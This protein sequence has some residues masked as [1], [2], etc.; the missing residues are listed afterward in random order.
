M[1]PTHEECLG[2][3]LRNVWT[4]L[5]G[6]PAT[7]RLVGGT[8]AALYCGHRKSVDADI[9]SN[10]P[11]HHPRVIRRWLNGNIGPHKVVHA[12]N[13]P[14]TKF[15]AT[16]T[17]PKLDIVGK[18][19]WKWKGEARQ[20]ANGLW[21]AAPCDLVAGKLLAMSDRDEE[22]DGWDIDALHKAGA[23]LGTGIQSFLTQS[24]EGDHERLL[25]KLATP[26]RWPHLSEHMA[27]I[28]GINHCREGGEIPAPVRYEV[29]EL[30][31]DWALVEIQIEYENRTVRAT[32]SKLEEVTKWLVETG[33]VRPE[34]LPV[35]EFNLRKEMAA[36]R[37]IGRG[38]GRS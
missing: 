26:S 25:K 22:R 27:W 10:V 35:V 32:G 7:Y 21:V 38:I 33:V 5:G 6:L 14:Y 15:S 36:K 8:A 28:E 1:Q 2:E 24:D 4:D 29:T 31:Q 18:S 16:A 9:V 13:R 12:K 19:P 23:D 34:D 11:A 37:A 17:T 3:K 30:D 20:A